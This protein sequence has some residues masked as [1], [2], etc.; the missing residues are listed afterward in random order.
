MTRTRPVLLAIDGRSGAGKTTLA[1]A[2]VTRLRQEGHDV[3]L[4]HLEDVYTGWRGLRGGIEIYV[5]DVLTPL[6]AGRTA[7]WTPWDWDA[8]APASAPRRTPPHAVVLCEGV[9]AGSEAARPL[10]TATLTVTA[11]AA[12]RRRRAL[13]RDGAGYEPWW[14]VWAEQEAALVPVQDGPA[15]LTVQGTDPVSAALTW[16]RAALGSHA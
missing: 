12:T 3:G 5:R 13:E 2:V 9:G 16:A 11:D 14:E 10:L 1:R 4:F 8:G 6:A 15:D 7:T